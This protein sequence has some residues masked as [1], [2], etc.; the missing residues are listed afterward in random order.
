MASRSVKKTTARPSA[1]KAKGRHPI[2][3]KLAVPRHAQP[4]T[5]AK[6]RGP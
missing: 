4:L 3:D 6:D 2:L 1:T 5:E